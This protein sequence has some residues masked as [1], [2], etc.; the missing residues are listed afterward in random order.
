MAEIFWGEASWP[1]KGTSAIGSC[2]KPDARH[3]DPELGQCRKHGRGSES[4]DERA[5]GR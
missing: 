3:L 1:L 4:R 5:A 2:V